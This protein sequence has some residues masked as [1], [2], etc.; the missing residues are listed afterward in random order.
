MSH[1]TKLKTKIKCLVTLQRVIEAMGFSIKENVKQCRG[2]QGELTEAEMVI[3]TKS[4]YDIGVVKTVDGYE[5]VGDWDM[6]QVRAGIEQED[7]VSELNKKYAYYRI[8]DEV[9]KQGY[10]VIEEQEDEKQ[11]MTVKVRRWR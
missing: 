11:V 3:D 6:L 4:S 5:L 1:F 9:A 10:D 8:M 7:F 2:Y